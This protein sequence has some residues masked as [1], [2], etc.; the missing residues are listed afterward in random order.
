[1]PHFASADGV[2]VEGNL[3]IDDI[4]RVEVDHLNEWGGKP[5]ERGS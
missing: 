3:D 5:E 1:M 2:T 4:I